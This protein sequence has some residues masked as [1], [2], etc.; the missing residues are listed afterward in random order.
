MSDCGKTV[1]WELLGNEETEVAGLKHAPLIWDR[2]L[3]SGG[4]SPS[5]TVHSPTPD[6]HFHGRRAGKVL[7]CAQS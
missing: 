5:H 1:W 4:R 3:A 6:A 7:L 2:R